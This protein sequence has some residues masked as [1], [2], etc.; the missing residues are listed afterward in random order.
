MIE[1]PPDYSRMNFTYF[2]CYFSS[3]VRNS[4]LL[5]LL[6]VTLTSCSV[7]ERLAIPDVPYAIVIQAPRLVLESR[8]KVSLAATVVSVNGAP[9]ANQTVSWTS[10]NNE[11]ALVSVDGVLTAKAVRGAAI[12]WVTIR[13]TAATVAGEVAIGVKPASV[14]RVNIGNGNPSIFVGDTIAFKAKAFDSSGT[15]LVG[16][17][18]SWS[19][20]D[21]T[22]G[23]VSAVGMFFA[24]R[25]GSV[26][27]RLSSQLAVDSTVIQVF[28]PASLRI[29]PSTISSGPGHTCAVRIDDVIM[30]WGANGSGQIG[31]GFASDMQEFPVGV[32][33][34][35]PMAQVS[36]GFSTRQGSGTYRNFSCSISLSRE[37]WCWGFN[38]VGSVGDGTT[39]DRMTPTRVAGGLRFIRLASDYNTTCGIVD[40]GKIYCWGGTLPGRGYWFSSGSDS[41][42]V[43]T[44]VESSEEFKDV[45]LRFGH[46]CALNQHGMAFCWGRNNAGQLGDGTYIDRSAPSPVLGGI[47]FSSIVT[48]LDFSCGISLQG[49]VYCWGEGAFRATSISGSWLVPFVVSGNLKFSSISAGLETICGIERSGRAYCWG[50]TF[51]GTG[52][53]VRAL[54]PTPVLS[55]RKFSAVSVGHI[56]MCGITDEG[57]ALCW[58][59]PFH[60]Q[61]GTGSGTDIVS[62]PT[63]VFGPYRF[64]VP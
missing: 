50:N 4:G 6:A 28:Q 33:S 40:S 49:K 10:L 36:V 3:L 60:G 56:H 43:P 14:A 19:V 48:G 34:S 24:R 8:E 16:R 22:I 54:S 18:F 26:V 31:Q 63:P 11:V 27:I 7:S 23:M 21:T 35:T 15:S 12:E 51:L 13:A 2:Q 39:S 9:V 62:V 41:I 20:S 17:S 37:A 47:S 52:G 53:M 64:R 29:M 38:E 46:A 25:A 44:I 59:Y 30:C 1:R 57:I 42:L 61:T 32:A 45:S 5:G 55:D 58:G